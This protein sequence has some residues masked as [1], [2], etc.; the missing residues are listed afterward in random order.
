MVS[1]EFKLNLYFNMYK[2][3]PI[4]SR[5]NFRTTFRKKHGRYQY[6]PELILMIEEYQRKKYGET[7]WDEYTW[8]VSLKKGRK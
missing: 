3:H 5:D 4:G 2:D 7:I 1:E 6:L 8:L